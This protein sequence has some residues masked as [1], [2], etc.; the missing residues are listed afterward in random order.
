[1]KKTDA[2]SN[3][4]RA[5]H[6]ALQAAKT[7]GNVNAEIAAY[8]KVI[9]LGQN[10][11]PNGEDVVDKKSL[12]LY[13]SYNNLGDALTKKNRN[14]IIFDKDNYNLALDYYNQAYKLARDNAEKIAVLKRMAY[15]YQ[16]M[17]DRDA[18]DK[19][20]LQIIELSKDKDKR[21]AYVALAEMQ[22]DADAAALFY[23]R[24]LEYVPKEEI[25]V[26]G[27]CLNTLAICREL[28]VLYQEL[29]FPGQQKRIYDLMNKTALLAVRSLEDKIDAED[30]RLRK[31]ALFA[32]L[33]DVNK[34]YL[35][36]DD[37]RCGCLYRRMNDL[38]MNGEEL[39]FGGV[40]YSKAIIRKLL[41][42]P[43]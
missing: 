30:D 1:M 16:L 27:K 3:L 6:Q 42:R 5:Y 2:N 14:K 31:L 13:W 35:H 17:K 11:F 32:K 34:N 38:L 25:D 12:I 37:S 10:S 41:S 8:S 9:E 4:V 18:F 7:A 40:K 33:I 24:A 20:F 26:V 22:K 23:E 29:N 36:A 19:C 21:E 28:M 15:S 43:H 39:D